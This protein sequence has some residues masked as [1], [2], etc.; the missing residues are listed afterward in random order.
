MLLEEQ[1]L[2]TDKGAT[3]VMRDIDSPFKMVEAQVNDRLNELVGVTVVLIVVL[4]DP[5]NRRA[6]LVKGLSEVDVKTT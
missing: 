1:I 6:R 4:A 2:L 5:P 3:D